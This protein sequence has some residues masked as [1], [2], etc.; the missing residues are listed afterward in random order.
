MNIELEQNI[1]EIGAK[2]D[3]IE[4]VTNALVDS[5]CGTNS[6]TQKDACSFAYLLQN[7]VADLKIKQEEIVKELNI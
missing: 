1:N 6:L 7:S 3:I 5:L 2:T 4:S